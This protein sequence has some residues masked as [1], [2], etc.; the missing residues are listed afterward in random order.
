LVAH[1][2]DPEPAPA[3]LSGGWYG[4]SKD[5]LSL[6]LAGYTQNDGVG[7]AAAPGKLNIW[8]ADLLFEKKLA[9]GVPTLELAYYKYKLGARDCGSGEPGAPACPALPPGATGPANSGGMA[10]GKAFLVGGGFIIPV[11]VGWGQ[12]QPFLRYQKFDRSVSATTVKSTDFGVNYLVN[13]PKVKVS[14]M[15]TKGNDTRLA[16]ASRDTNQFTLGVQLQY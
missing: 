8:N 7:T 5:I 14:A 12:F 2:L 3:H 1:I 11:T 4:G 13:G 10:D 16:V 15:Y 9:F 6:G